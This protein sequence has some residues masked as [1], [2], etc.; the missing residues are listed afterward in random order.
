M[1]SR[2]ADGKGTAFFA[3]V[4]EVADA[5]GTT[6]RSNGGAPT[7]DQMR[8]LLRRMDLDF[9]EDGTISKGLRLACP[10]EAEKATRELMLSVENDPECRRIIIEK[11]RLVMQKRA[12]KSTRRL[13]RRHPSGT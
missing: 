1:L 12:E 13:P 9:E 8:E 5:A 2:D 6:V 7:L 10:P 11:R 4:A 3:N